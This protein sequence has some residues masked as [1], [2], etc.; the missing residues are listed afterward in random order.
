MLKDQDNANALAAASLT[1]STT[2]STGLLTDPNEVGAAALPPALLLHTHVHS[3]ASTFEYY[4]RTVKDDS[5]IAALLALCA[6]A[7]GVGEVVVHKAGL[8]TLNKEV[9]STSPYL[10][11][12][13]LTSVFCAGVMCLPVCGVLLWV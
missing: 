3:P 8:H 10:T 2:S 5:A 12:P 4:A 7:I 13:Y 6:H 9:G 1:A 11:S